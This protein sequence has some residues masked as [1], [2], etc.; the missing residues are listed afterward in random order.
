MDVL[1]RTYHCPDHEPESLGVNEPVPK[2]YLG[3]L[4]HPFRPRGKASPSVEASVPTR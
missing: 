3:Q 1:F 2:S 4:L